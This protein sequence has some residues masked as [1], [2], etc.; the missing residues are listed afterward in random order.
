MSPHEIIDI[1]NYDTI[2]LKD[3]CQAQNRENVV[4]G[5]LLRTYNDNLGV[6]N[7]CKY[8]NDLAISNT[9]HIFG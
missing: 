5:K 1:K 7:V 3:G 9:P 6:E 4:M 8:D 2:S